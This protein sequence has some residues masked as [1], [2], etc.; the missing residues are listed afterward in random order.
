MNIFT[1]K[2][3]IIYKALSVDPNRARFC[4]KLESGLSQN[5][6]KKRPDNLNG[7]ADIWYAGYSGSRD[8][9]YNQSRYHAVNL[10][11][12]F[13]KGTVE[14]RC[15]NS[16][17]HAGKVKTYIQFC[18]AI[19][20]Q[21]IAQK[22]SSAKVTVS[23]NERYTFRCWLLRMGLIGDEFATARKFLLENL[24]GDIA[25]RHGESA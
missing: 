5:I 13:T 15:F 9:H 18:L 11:A 16:T 20:H 4:K 7:L 17:L 25:W 6:N 23:D 10:H 21:A 1:S 12:V 22:S 2:Q 19:S 3:D 24:E 8:A 14:F